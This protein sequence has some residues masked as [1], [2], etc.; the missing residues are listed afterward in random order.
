MKVKTTT[1]LEKYGF[2]KDKFDCWIYK[3]DDYTGE[4]GDQDTPLK[5]EIVVDE[6]R[7]IFFY[8]TNHHV[9]VLSYED[10]PTVAET[11]DA[12]T[13]DETIDMPPIIFELFKNDEIQPPNETA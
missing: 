10:Y 8:A 4:K 9:Q 5:I 11:E 3:I 7:E 1:N 12:Y 2:K 6:K 13:F